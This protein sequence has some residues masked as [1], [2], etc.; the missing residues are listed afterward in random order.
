M[1]VSLRKATK[2]LPKGCNIQLELNPLAAQ[3]IVPL[4]EV[5]ILQGTKE[6]M[7]NGQTRYSINLSPEKIIQLKKI[8]HH[9]MGFNIHNQ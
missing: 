4:F 7:A 5:E 2:P 6:P 9:L 3:Y 8:I 1:N